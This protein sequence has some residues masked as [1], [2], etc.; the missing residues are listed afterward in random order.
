MNL[1]EKYLKL[2]PERRKLVLFALALLA[3]V[4]FLM[5]PSASELRR[6]VAP[7]RLSYPSAPSAR[8]VKRSPYDGLLV[9]PSEGAIMAAPE[10]PRR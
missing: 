1:T 2:T 3:A 5:L 6:A 9:A 10:G 8:P 7:L 4:A